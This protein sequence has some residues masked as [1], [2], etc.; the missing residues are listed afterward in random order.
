MPFIEAWGVSS[1][2][3]KLPVKVSATGNWKDCEIVSS[4]LTQNY[5][6]ATSFI[7]LKI[8]HLLMSFDMFCSSLQIIYLKSKPYVY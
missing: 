5:I 7:C 2:D 8:I 1:D 4:R 6:Q 3:C